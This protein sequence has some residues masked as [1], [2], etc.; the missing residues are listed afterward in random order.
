M[1]L[2]YFDVS[3]GS[4]FV[5]DPEGH[6]LPDLGAAEELAVEAATD[7]ARYDFIEGATRVVVLKINDE[8][9]RGLCT[10]T[11]SV[12]VQ[13]DPIPPPAG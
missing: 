6:E 7:M 5:R 2:F 12:H 4:T 10:V 1:P 9:H 11:V 8:Q 13:R 3:H